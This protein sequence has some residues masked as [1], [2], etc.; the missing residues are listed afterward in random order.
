MVRN[1]S[2]TWSSSE[3][4]ILVDEL[5]ARKVLLCLYFTVS[6]SFLSPIVRTRLTCRFSVFNNDSIENIFDS[7]TF[8]FPIRI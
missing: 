1:A 8:V 2:A 5:I 3:T 6:Y 4:E 7:M